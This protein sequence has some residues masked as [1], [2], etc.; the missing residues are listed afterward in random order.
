MQQQSIN[1]VIKCLFNPNP[2]KNTS[3][4]RNFHNP[5]FLLKT[6]RPHGS[7]TEFN[8]KHFVVYSESLFLGFFK[9][10]LFYFLKKIFGNFLNFSSLAFFTIT[11][12][13][14]S[15]YSLLFPN[16][17]STCISV[18]KSLFRQISFRCILFLLLRYT[19]YNSP[20]LSSNSKTSKLLK[21][22]RRHLKILKILRRH[23]VDI[24]SLTFN[25]TLSQM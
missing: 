21:T 15:L 2:H 3:N 5:R 23:L 6:L 7:N 13:F 18:P 8:F 4:T 16:Q 9:E 22:L 20:A 10:V 12:V 11:V 24:N 19:T 17:S 1:K 25:L 14:L